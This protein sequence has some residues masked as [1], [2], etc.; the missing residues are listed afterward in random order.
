MPIDALAHPTRRQLQTFRDGLLSDAAARQVDEHLADCAPCQAALESLSEDALV[1]RCRQAGPGVF[2]ATSTP[3]DTGASGSMADTPAAIPT[4][5]ADHP[6]Y[7]IVGVLGAGG[8]GA[9]YKA[10]HI[11]MDRLV[12]L[13]VIGNKLTDNPAAIERFH[14]EARAAAQLTHSN[15]V[16]A[17][18]A[19]QAGGTHFLVMEF[20]EGV[21]LAKQVQDG[22]P[23]P[24][25]EACICAR[26]AALGLQHAFEKGMVHRDIKPHNLMWTPNGWVKIL[27]FGLARFVSESQGADGLTHEGAL[28]GTLDYLAPEQ[29]EDAHSADIRADLYS[30][31]CT[32]YFLLT[33]QPPFPGGSVRHKLDAHL[34]DPPRPVH[35]LRPDVPPE[36][37]QI[38]EQMLAK[39]P[40][41]RYQTPAEVAQAL[42]PFLRPQAIPCQEHV[43]TAPAASPTSLLAIPVTLPPQP[44]RRR[45][46]PWAVASTAAA[47]LGLFL[48]AYFVAPTIIRLATNQGIL[49]IET[50][51]EAVEVKIKGQ[52]VTIVDPKTKREIWVKAGDGEIEVKERNGL[53]FFTKSF[54]MTRD[55]KVIVD[56]HYEFAQ[57]KLAPP[58]ST[59]DPKK[60]G[61]KENVHAQRL[62]ELQQDDE[63][64][65]E[66]TEKAKALVDALA[67]GDFA[68]ASKDFDSTMKKTLTPDKLKA[69]W[70]AEVEAAGA[71]QK[72][73]IVRAEK[74]GESD[75]VIVTCQFEKTPLKI[76]VVFNADNEIM[77]LWLESADQQASL[78]RDTKGLPLVLDVDFGDPKADLRFFGDSKEGEHQIIMKAPGG[79]WSAPGE[80]LP[81]MANYVCEVEG[82]L[83]ERADGSWSLSFG[84]GVGYHFAFE[85]REGS[86]GG[87]IGLLYFDPRKEIVPWKDA[88]ALKPITQLNTVRLEVTG[89][90]MRLFANGQH[91]LDHTDNRLLPGFVVLTT[92]ANSGTVEARFRRLRIWRVEPPGTAPHHPRKALLHEAD[93]RKQVAEFPEAKDGACGYDRGYYFVKAGKGMAQVAGNS[94]GKP[95]GDFYAEVTGRVAE[96]TGGSWALV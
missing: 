38:V 77:G 46:L 63:K 27:D 3:A 44:T 21:S 54:K 65:T 70:K 48:L 30:L 28:M 43:R 8:M 91:V 88:P 37:S 10:R 59:I 26:Q 66:Q 18:D 5:L 33:G 76:K 22:G 42:V 85:V 84:C 81:P 32:L 14:R 11:V 24:V 31:G 50:D 25:H 86:R 51:D 78:P 41:D 47:L 9:V 1:L 52:G 45:R 80:H 72:R 53:Q 94:P 82:R 35:D 12:A 7:R 17:Y 58:G 67:R 95:V 19:D 90:Q 68:A 6:R 55:G 36:L 39:K 83:A 40:Q 89:T 2:G 87:Q 92:Q 96:G 49:I 34:H 4:D 69:T 29:A 62:R 74:S 60:R 23:L 56:V 79:W 73:T 57:A 64:L 13:K 15:I 61:D 71:F 75:D 16:A 93:F 20:V